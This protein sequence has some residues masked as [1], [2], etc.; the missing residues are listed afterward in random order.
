MPDQDPPEGN[1]EVLDL[2]RQRIMERYQCTENEATERLRASMRALMEQ[3][4]APILPPNPPPEPPLHPNLPQEENPDPPLKKKATYVDFDLNTTIANQIP[5][6]PSE[7]AVGRMEEIEY[8]ELWY[9]TTEGCNEASKIT[10]T[11][12]D[13]TFG[14]LDTKSG[15]ALQ[16]IKT[17]KASKNAIGD[18][19]LSWEQIMTAR[20]TMIATA[21]R[22]GW[23]QK[24]T[25]ALAQFY[26]NLESLKASGYNPR[27]LI[28]YH[29]VV[30]KQWHDALKGRGDSFNISH[31]NETLFAKLEN[32][33]RDQDQ[34]ETQ[35]QASNISLT[36]VN[37]PT[38]KPTPRYR[39]LFHVTS[40]QL[41]STQRNVT[42]HASP[43]NPTQRSHNHL[44]LVQSTLPIQLEKLSRREMSESQASHRDRGRAGKHNRSSGRQRSSRSRSPKT[45]S[46]NHRFR[47]NSPDQEARGLS[48]C[49]V[50]LSR[51][52][53]PI[54]KC[55]A[56]NLWDGQHKSRCAR[57]DDGQIVDI[58][59]R[60]L[61]NNWNQTIGCKDKSSRHIHECSG[62]GESSH[63]A[64]DCSFAEKE[65][66]PNPSRR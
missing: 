28:L 16:P 54:R 40:T 2:V 12:A 21:N 41:N 23:D 59:G 62:C 13:N 39:S 1:A 38:L 64:Q 58:N 10:P 24:L 43:F 46:P 29:A 47:R 33:V 55:K 32:K 66:S 50:C 35:R 56:A 6:T 11:A 14:I 63:G 9:F 27:A 4:E 37:E 26:I 22:V 15:L 53:H 61:C 51:K 5:H 18:E 31:I 36:P 19:A 17:T 8:V 52:K 49:P 60:T 25:L 48:A 7:Y 42:P 3:R 34:E 30:R 57:T 45:R 44:V 65:A 20:H